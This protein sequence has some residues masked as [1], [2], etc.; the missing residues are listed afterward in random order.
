MSIYFL[1]RSKIFWFSA[2]F[3]PCGPFPIIRNTHPRDMGNNQPKQ[4]PRPLPVSFFLLTF[5]PWPA[6]SVPAIYARAI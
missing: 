1:W 3:R 6:P 4:R 5:A 2:Y